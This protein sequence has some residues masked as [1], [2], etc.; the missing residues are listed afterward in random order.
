M[1]ILQEAAD[2]YKYL[3]SYQFTFIL[4]KKGSETKIVLR[5][6]DE[7][8]PHLIGL[9][10]LK[11]LN[12]FTKNGKNLGKEAVLP[13]INGEDITLEKIS[14][15][16]HF[17]NDDFSHSIENRI[18]YFPKIKTLFEA[19]LNLNEAYFM[20]YK[21]KAYSNIDADYLLVIKIEVNSESCYLNLFIKKDSHQNKGEVEYYI[22]ISFFPRLNTNYQNGQGKMT[23]LQKSKHNTDTNEI[24]YTHS[25]YKKETLITTN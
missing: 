22:P 20:F 9:D 5:S 12:L 10:K 19:N 4:G 24:L 2:F 16:S 13:R 25:N 18:R 11:D 14:K 7:H 15:S 6:K 21:N 17:T 1:S 23:L 3:M 8:F